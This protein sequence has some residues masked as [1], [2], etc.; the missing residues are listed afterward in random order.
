MTVT[1]EPA[2]RAHLEW[3]GYVQPVGL[4]VSPA[5]LV[6]AQAFVNKNVAREHGLFLARVEELS[7]AGGEKA[8]V[9]ADLPGFLTAVAGWR[10][11]DLVPVAGAER[12]NASRHPT[13]STLPSDA[14][15]S[16]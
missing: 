13:A 16:G 15:A 6:A 8:P 14:N 12:A 7:V 4:V 5:A 9:L 1:R 11:S 10:P 2:Y 3:L